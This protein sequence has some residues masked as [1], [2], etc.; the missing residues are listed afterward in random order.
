MISAVPGG[1]A[2]EKLLR[3]S[4]TTLQQSNIHIANELFHYVRLGTKFDWDSW[5]SLETPTILGGCQEGIVSRSL[6]FDTS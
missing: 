5:H 6:I 2:P 3:K 1:L 4:P